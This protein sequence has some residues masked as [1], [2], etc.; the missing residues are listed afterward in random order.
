LLLPQ[1]IEFW[2]TLIAKV[3]T[4]GLPS[5]QIEGGRSIAF[6]NSVKAASNKKIKIMHE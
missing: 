6:N 1:E 2:Q 3:K 4:T 5:L